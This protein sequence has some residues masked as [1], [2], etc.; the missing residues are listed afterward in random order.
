[1]RNSI[2]D[3]ILLLDQPLPSRNM[4]LKDNMAATTKK[5]KGKSS[6]CAS[7]RFTLASLPRPSDKLVWDPEQTFLNV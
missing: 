4:I 6:D 3:R 7:G 5:L 1:M 2:C